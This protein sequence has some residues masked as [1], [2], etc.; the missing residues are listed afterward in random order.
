ML[1]ILATAVLMIMAAST[2]AAEPTEATV[3]AQENKPVQQS[4]K[5]DCERREE[6][7]S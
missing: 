5:R 7:V 6:G 3:V 1:R 2:F 4:P